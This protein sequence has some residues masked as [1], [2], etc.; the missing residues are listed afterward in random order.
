MKWI[1]YAAPVAVFGVVVAF[2]LIGLG[3]DPHTLPSPLIGKPAPAFTL[4]RLASTGTGQVSL[5]DL[6]GKP[7]LLN[8]FASWCAPCL[9]EHPVL[10]ALA[11]SGAVPIVGINYKD[12][13]ANAT[14]WLARN[15]NPF[16]QVLVDQDGRVSIDFGVYGVP[17]SYL[18]DAA[19]TIRYKHVGPLTQA[20]VE[21]ELMPL[22][23][24]VKR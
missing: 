22:I 21:R 8:M 12:E 24:G 4:S 14:R 20:V 17:E 16:S 15:G 5:N 19:G 10:M 13:A 9:E 3:R 1:R 7:L 2:L 11:R 23:E 18:I 6:K